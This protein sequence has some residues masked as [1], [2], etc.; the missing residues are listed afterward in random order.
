MKLTDEQEA[1]VTAAL[2]VAATAGHMSLIGPAGCGKTTT[3]RAIAHKAVTPDRGVL[4]LAPTH[5]ARQ[6][7]AAARL[8][9]GVKRQT[10]HRFNGVTQR[11]WRD[12]DRFDINDKND[13]RTVAE[14]M[15]RYRLVVVDESSMVNKEHA[16]KALAANE[17]KVRDA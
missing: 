3:I 4:L 6:Q 12:Q 16:E 5:K 13:A 17:T 14:T 15:A 9:N 7:L 11:D 8:P 1:A 2:Q 10:I